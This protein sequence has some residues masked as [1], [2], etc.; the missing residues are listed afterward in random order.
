MYRKAAWVDWETPPQKSC[1]EA[2]AFAASLTWEK[3]SA[4]NFSR[5]LVAGDDLLLGNIDPA[6]WQSSRQS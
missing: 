5:H 2:T 6:T 3:Q 4:S 1:I